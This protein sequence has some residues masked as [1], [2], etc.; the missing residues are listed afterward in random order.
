MGR[1]ADDIDQ[2]ISELH[3]STGAT[4]VPGTADTARLQ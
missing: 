3:A 2:L 1:D 4:P